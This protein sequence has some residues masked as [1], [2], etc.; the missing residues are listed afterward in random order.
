VYF[1]I[2]RKELLNPLKNLVSVVEQRQTLPILGHLLMRVKDQV[3]HLTA[4]NSEVEIVCSIPLLKTSKND[5][6]TVPKKIFDI[7]RSLP[8]NSQIQVT[9]EDNH[10]I[11]KS[12]KSRFTLSC[13]S[14]QDF[15]ESPQIQGAEFQITSHLFK[16]LVSKT[17]F[18]VA[19]NDVRYYLT[20]LL[21]EISENKMSLV[22]TDGHRMA[23]AECDFDIHETTKVIIPR[24][25]VLELLKLL[26]ENEN[27]IKIS[28]SYSHIK[29]ELSDSLIMSSKLID[30][31]FPDW[32][33]VIP[34][35]SDKIVLAQTD[36]LKQSLARVSLL[37]NEKYKGVKLSLAKNLMVINARNPQQEEA[38]EE[39]PVDYPR[40]KMEVGFNG[41]YITEV[42]NIVST[43][44]V[45]LVFSEHN[46]SVLM[47]E[48]DTD[49][50]KWIIMS[51]RL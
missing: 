8:E 6:T 27:H 44:G 12:G 9:N 28:V 49:D 19:V 36:L 4:T 18:C 2:S 5:E 31:S 17:A 20:G 13:L 29:F 25:A 11:L 26:P 24:K 39:L 38:T 1:E 23:V 47:T 40:E 37:S 43:P 16:K 34:A 3:L 22:G 41:V 32:R 46:A 15:P 50:Y 21:L 51:M 33:S 7:V 30:G 35:G 14:A 10:I 48:E 45:K 42:L